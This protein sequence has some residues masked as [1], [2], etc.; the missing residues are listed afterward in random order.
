ML[1][2]P[3][4]PRR[5]VLDG[6]EVFEREDARSSD[7]LAFQTRPK[8]LPDCCFDLRSSN[9]ARRQWGHVVPHLELDNDVAWLGFLVFV[10]GK[11]NA[12]NLSHAH[13]LSTTGDPTDKP[14]T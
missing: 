11:I 14:L 13:P 8:P 3:G 7:A 2:C 10:P 6:V 9:F 5:R 12:F 1:G 4:N